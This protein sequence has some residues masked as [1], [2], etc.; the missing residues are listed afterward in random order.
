MKII[1]KIK[2][3]S[4]RA[5]TVDNNPKKMNLFGAKRKQRDSKD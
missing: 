1:E 4:E 3:K 5:R 2:K